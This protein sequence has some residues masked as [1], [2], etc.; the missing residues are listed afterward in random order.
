MV[1]A[2][3]S[4]GIVIALYLRINSQP[5]TECAKSI[6]RPECNIRWCKAPL[7]FT[8]LITFCISLCTDAR[9]KQLCLCTLK[10]KGNLYCKYFIEIKDQNR[11]REVDLMVM[12]LLPD[13]VWI[14]KGS[15][16]F[17]GF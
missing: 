16:C 3:F 4:D 2:E 15:R 12:V 13:Y 8:E 7:T 10:E 14:L 6:S 5:I 17:R 1:V 11:S 9:A